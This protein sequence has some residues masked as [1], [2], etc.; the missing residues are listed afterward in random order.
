MDDRAARVW[1]GLAEIF[2]GSLTTSFGATCPPLWGSKI[3]A[4]S[5]RQ[6]EHGLR[7]MADWDSPYAPSLGQFVTACK[8]GW[9][10]GQ[11]ALPAPTVD[12][13]AGTL[14]RLLMS[15]IMRA[16][17]VHRD[18]MAELV[19]YKRDV[20]HQL[21]TAYGD[22]P[23]E[24]DI[25]DIRDMERAVSER[26]DEIIRQDR[27]PQT[28]AEYSAWAETEFRHDHARAQRARIASGEQVIHAC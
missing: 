9:Q 18:R 20:A 5:D 13:W 28:A 4:L 2:G 14:N 6:L 21:R 17:G 15:K 8:S 7:C 22:A 16:Q 23:T 19:A 27:R 26:M 1:T 24:Q 11:K 3:A 10:H 25:E 12:H